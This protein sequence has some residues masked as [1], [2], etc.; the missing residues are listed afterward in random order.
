MIMND[1]PDKET[2]AEL[3]R[4]RARNAEIEAELQDLRGVCE[5]REAFEYTG[6][7]M[8]VIEDDMTI[9]MG[10][11]MMLEITGYSKEELR[12]PKCWVDYVVEED[13][14]RMID[15]HRQRREHPEQTPDSYEFRLLD[16]R[17]GIR[18]V[19]AH[20]SMIPGTRKSIVSLV[21]INDR[22]TMEE[23]LRQS[24]ERYRE[25]FENANDIIYVHDF[26]GTFISVNAAGLKAF[27]FGRDAVGQMTIH[28]VVH[29]D[30]LPLALDRL[31]RKLD[32]ETL[33]EPYE[34]LTRTYD[35]REVWVEVNTRLIRE[36]GAAV[37]VQGIARDITERKHAERRLLESQQR[38]R[39]TTELLP[40]VVCE[41]DTERRVTYVNR[42]G[43]ESFG[44]TPED[45]AE[46]VLIDD[47]V[48]PEDWPVMLGR[49]Q[50]IVQGT[51]LGPQEYRMVHK[52]GTMREYL[53]DSAPVRRGDT[54]VRLRTCLLDVHD[55][56]EAQRRM[57]ESELRFR[58]VY[59]Q[60]PVGIALFAPDGA[61][62][63]MNPAFTAMFPGLCK[64]NANKC[65]LRRMS[66]IDER[67]MKK[68]RA[69]EGVQWE[70][71]APRGTGTEHDAVARY[72]SWHITPLQGGRA[73]ESVLLAQ[74]M[75][76]TERREAEER[77]L[78]EVRR[79][80][81]EAQ[82]LVADLRKDLVHTFS[83]CDMVSRSPKMREVFD[84]LPQIA[85]TPVTVLVCGESGTGK[86]IVARSLHQLSPRK[87]KP[88]VAI[89]CSALPDNLLESELFGYK[90]GAFT[91]AKKD[92]PGKFALAEGGT[93][94]LDEIGDISPAMQVKLLRVLQE[95]AYE[96]LGATG[97]V[98]ADVR[99]LAATNR[100]LQ[101]M[102]RDGAFREDLYYRIK[103]LQINLPPLRDRLGDI[104]LLA[105]HFVEL[106]NR[107]YGRDIRGV[108]Q[109]ALD[110]LLAHPFPGNIREL[111]NTIEHAFVFCKNSVI[112][113]EH[114][115]VELRMSAAENSGS[116]LN[117]VKSLDELEKMYIEN[118]L[119]ETNG[120][121][122]RAAE[123]LG[124]HKATLFR[125]LRRLN[126]A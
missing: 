105:A 68:V 108:S 38:F 101:Q 14:P 61:S 11:R 3:E 58:T 43:L 122:A 32:G 51:V 15:Y 63:D 45:I 67:S 111:E 57:L 126:I 117:S 72:L 87:S 55:R 4:L 88:F 74:V 114:L 21:D 86:E 49:F 94:L 27:G 84:I 80:A 77:Q 30:Y 1:G 104:P 18:H 37:A 46:G 59:A 99:V 110:V 12:E 96:P 26:E 120:N 71:Y 113:P 76:I 47:L 90:A 81:D 42:L 7:A 39:E 112:T 93:L 53:L 115:P 60:S 33:N 102:V 92:K 62:I 75:D 83:F 95:R 52:D 64:D 35:G 121:R 13:R 6:T 54:I 25:L 78:S 29:P 89:N 28:D 100:D 48:H 123:R 91:D 119:A 66:E 50:Q 17:G 10:N 109:E 98:R 23:A 70:A 69:G 116:T 8:M 97:S 56:K 9:S 19:L 124:I 82:K 41:L 125:K 44:F 118:V 40:A 65:T 20:V 107:R 31:R 16:P 34:L 22:K 2:P 85:E 79:A 103:V 106:F 5:D 36:H 73:S 24:E